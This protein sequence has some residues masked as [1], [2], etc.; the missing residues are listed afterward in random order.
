M[1][2]IV[3]LTFTDIGIM[4]YNITQ[5]FRVELSAFGNTA[6]FYIDS[7]QKAQYDTTELSYDLTPEA[8]L[9]TNEDMTK[10]VKLDLCL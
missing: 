4:G 9:R 6:T 7:V 8:C 3:G 10:V 1:T 2:T 5:S